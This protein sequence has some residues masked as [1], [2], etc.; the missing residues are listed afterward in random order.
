MFVG[1]ILLMSVIVFVAVSVIM[2]VFVFFT[3]CVAIPS[4]SF[5]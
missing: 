1:V 5:H 4:K 2:F 3:H